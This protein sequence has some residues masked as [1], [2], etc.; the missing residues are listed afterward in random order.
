MSDQIPYHVFSFLPQQT[1]Q[2]LS[3]TLRWR[4]LITEPL[5][6]T[7]WGRCKCGSWRETIRE[8]SL[9]SYQES[10]AAG[11]SFPAAVPL[12]YRDHSIMDTMQPEWDCTNEHCQLSGS[13]YTGTCETFCL[14]HGTALYKSSTA[15]TDSMVAWMTWKPV[16]RS[17]RLKASIRRQP[18]RLC[19]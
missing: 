14:I 12:P 4:T 17:C 13:T 6:R 3:A 2:A 11:R 1:L 8:V 5:Q 15:L 7:H 16:R 9:L 19:S 18:Q 10:T